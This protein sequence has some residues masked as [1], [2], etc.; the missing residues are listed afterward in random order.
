MFPWEIVHLRTGK[1]TI[2]IVLHNLNCNLPEGSNDTALW[3]RYYHPHIALLVWVLT[4]VLSGWKP[5]AAGRHIELSWIQGGKLREPR[6]KMK[7]S[8][9]LCIQFEHSTISHCVGDGSLYLWP[10]LLSV[11]PQYNTYH[12]TIIYTLAGISMYQCLS[13]LSACSNQSCQCT[14]TQ[15]GT[16]TTNALSVKYEVTNVCYMCTLN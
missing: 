3:P 9:G 12:Q 6:A 14:E 10:N 2:M 13:M 8:E 1:H 11:S 4:V 15:S 5:V 7:E 16:Q